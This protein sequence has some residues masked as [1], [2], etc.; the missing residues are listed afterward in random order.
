MQ[1]T[2]LYTP[3]QMMADYQK[4]YRLASPHLPVPEI[5]QGADGWFRILTFGVGAAPIRGQELVQM[6]NRLIARAK[7]KR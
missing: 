6:T 7:A 3:A 1:I 5:T 4:A 2:V